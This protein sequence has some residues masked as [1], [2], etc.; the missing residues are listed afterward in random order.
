M[1]MTDKTKSVVL[2]SEDLF[3]LMS[4]FD[5]ALFCCEPSLVE[6][7]I[8]REKRTLSVWRSKLI[9]K[10][11]ASGL[12]DNEGN[13]SAA[14]RQMIVPLMKPGIYVADS[15]SP[16][17]GYVDERR[18]CV[19]VFGDMAT[20]VEKR[21]GIYGGWT[22]T[23]L[24][25]KE[26]VANAI[27]SLHGM[28][29]R[30]A[31]NSPAEHIVVPNDSNGAWVRSA[32]Q[33]DVAY[34]QTIAT[35]IG[36]DATRLREVGSWW[37]REG[38]RAQNSK[39]KRDEKPMLEYSTRDFTGCVFG[40]TG[41]IRSAIPVSGPLKTRMLRLFPAK[42]FSFS[43]ERAPRVQDPDDWWDHEEL[44]D[45]GQFVTGDFI[46]SENQLVSLL[47]SVDENPNS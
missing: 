28:R 29:D 34:L 39:G 7:Y 47:L 20:L 41:G 16:L 11:S 27:L 25:S 4:G 19:Y 31:F 36:F 21:R 46:A 3:V 33:G 5:I 15:D 2:S 24:E 45:S 10:H 12:V 43:I 18:A 14:L 26:Q 9:R 32:L 6:R 22:L 23:A 37:Q 8:G 30:L 1:E 17:E 42:G 35:R 38:L 40:E 13:P 44:H